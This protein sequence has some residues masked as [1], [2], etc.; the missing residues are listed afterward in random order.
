VLRVR[1][2]HVF[3][4]VRGLRQPDGKYQY[5]KYC[6]DT[7]S[8]ALSGW[9]RMLRVGNRVRFQIA[10]PHGERF[11]QIHEDECPPNDVRGIPLKIQTGGSPTAIDAVIS[12]LDVQ[13]EQIVKDF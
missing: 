6:H 9:L 13:A 1:E 12:Y 11:I 3:S 8:E 10:G 5:R 7:S 4:G 2:G